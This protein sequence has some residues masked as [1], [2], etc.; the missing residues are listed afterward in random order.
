[1]RPCARLN[2]FTEFLPAK[3]GLEVIVGTHPIPQDCYLTHES[4]GTWR[5]AQ[6][7]QLIKPMLTDEET[8]KAYE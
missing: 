7:Q 5:S 8:R 1:M 3:Y 2:A 6:W 4:L